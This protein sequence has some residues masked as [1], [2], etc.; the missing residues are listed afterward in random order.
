M[1]CFRLLTE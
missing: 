1:A